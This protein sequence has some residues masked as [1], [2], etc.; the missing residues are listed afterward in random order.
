M[1]NWSNEIK[2]DLSKAKESNIDDF[3]TDN[4]SIRAIIIF[5]YNFNTSLIKSSSS[6]IDAK[7]MINAINVK[8]KN[9][10]TIIKKLENFL[11]VGYEKIEAIGKFSDEDL[12][13]S[14]FAIQNRNED[15][16]FCGIVFE[17]FEFV[18]QNLVPKISQAC[19][20]EF[21]LSVNNDIDNSIIYSCDKI[22]FD[23]LT[24]H[25]PLWLIPGFSLGIKMKSG[26]IEDLVAERYYENLI[27]LGAL[28]FILIIGI[29]LIYRN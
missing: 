21:I 4:P 7:K 23:Q 29:G 9:N 3:I 1:S 6:L 15:I 20:D 18:R 25:K 16:K 13:L 22:G 26:N 19:G 10:N 27:V 5:D 8:L 24:L 12:N 2:I 14:V 17:P 11:N 28:A